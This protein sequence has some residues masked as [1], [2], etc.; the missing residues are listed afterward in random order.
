MVRH[1]TVCLPDN[2]L[3][4]SVDFYPSFIAL[5]DPSKQITRSP[6][7]LCTRAVNSGVLL[8]QASAAAKAR[9]HGAPIGGC[10]G[11]SRGRESPVAMGSFPSLGYSCRPGWTALQL[12]R[13]PAKL[14]GGVVC[15]TSSLSHTECIKWFDF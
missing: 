1:S 9:Q 14:P 2:T 4:M 12:L 8:F 7:S 6:L 10:D 5:A 11:S 15:W 3:Y 13:M